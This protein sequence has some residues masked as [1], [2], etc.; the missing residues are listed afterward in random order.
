MK[1]NGQMQIRSIT[2]D[3]FKSLVAFDL[4]LSHFTC[5]IGLNGSGKSTVLQA[6]DFLSRL[7][8]GN[9]SGWLTQRQWKVSDLNSKLLRKSN[10]DFE[11]FLREGSIEF[12]WTG[13][14][15]R[16]SQRCTQ[17]SLVLNGAEILRV[18]EGRLSMEGGGPTAQSLVGKIGF[19]YQGSVLSQLKDDALPEAGLALKTFMRNIKSL[20]LLAPQY[21]RQ[22]ARDSGGELGLS[23]ERLSAFIH[24]LSSSQRR[25]L[26]QQLR[27]C[28]PHLTGIHT[29]SLRSGWKQLEVGELFADRKIHSE[30][31]HVNDGMLRL[32]AILSEIL[33]EDQFLLFDEI[34]NGVNSE[35]VEFL[36]DT[37]VNAR[38]QVLVTTH[39]P[40]ILNYLDDDIARG[41]VQYLYKTPQGFTRSVPFFAIP[42][43]SEKLEVMGPGEAFV[44]T[45]LTRL[46][47]EIVTMP[48]QTPGQSNADTR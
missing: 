23:G 9:L 20:D 17:E 46:Y 5:L 11:V 43:V 1:E 36:L 13:S 25:S 30:A 26:E 40:M 28:Y 47:E 7:F 38:Q 48:T 10:I 32:I 8:R 27:R 14:F 42:S 34:E 21:L 2:V 44:D 6:V 22:R 19:D 33:T 12:R 29:T 3:N 37:L 45:N 15:N 16:Y 41:G 4:A 18:E 24:E 31:R 35:L 39:S